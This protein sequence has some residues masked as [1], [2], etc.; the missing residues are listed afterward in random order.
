MKK[1]YIIGFYLLLLCQ[2]T[3]H[4]RIR[5]DCIKTLDLEEL[6]CTPDSTV[7]LFDLHGVLVK[8]DQVKLMRNFLKINGKLKFLKSAIRKQVTHDL[9]EENQL[10][11]QCKKYRKQVIKT[12]NS[13]KIKPKMLSLLHE[14]KTLDYKLLLFSNIGADAFD[15]LKQREEFISLFGLFDDLIISG[16]QNDYERKPNQAFYNHALSIARQSHPEAQTFVLI[17]N[18]RKNIKRAKGMCGLR[19]SSTKK[20]RKQ[21]NALGILAKKPHQFVI[22]DH[23]RQ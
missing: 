19:Y 10:C 12:I 14:L 22:S 5:N 17:D 1:L 20:L 16:P 11:T 4:P 21:L 3:L 9:A 8:A 2:I 7:I 6:P 13:Q 23:N 18:K 15:D